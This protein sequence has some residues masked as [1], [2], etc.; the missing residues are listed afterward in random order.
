MYEE[1]RL[2]F[3]KIFG[4]DDCEWKTVN[5]YDSM[6]QVSL[7]T[8]SRAF[9]GLE[10]SRNENFLTSY[11]RYILAFGVGTIVVGELPRLFKRL[12]VPAFN[13]P[14]RYYRRRTLS[15]VVPE[16][17]KE[18]SRTSTDRQGDNFIRQCARVSMKPAAKGSREDPQL[19]AESM[20]MMV[21]QF[22]FFLSSSLSTSG[23]HVHR[24]TLQTRASPQCLLPPSNCQ[25]SFST[26]WGPIPS[27]TSA[28]GYEKRQ[29]RS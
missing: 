21:R 17:V 2:G 9:F 19:L 23:S 25:T 24:L 16:V 15:M 13:L 22:L 11:S 26:F 6:Q 3:D 5:V 1:I 27:S 7:S 14:L 4:V 18:L 20:M 29:I 28:R 12:L 8:M 10:L